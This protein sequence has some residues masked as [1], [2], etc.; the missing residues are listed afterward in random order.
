MYEL[1]YDQIPEE[2]QKETFD[3]LHEAYTFAIEMLHGSYSHN[4]TFDEFCNE[5]EANGYYLT[6]H[7][8]LLLDEPDT[9]VG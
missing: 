5:L 2:E 1:T 8:W 4:L 9:E 6:N 7:D 3:T